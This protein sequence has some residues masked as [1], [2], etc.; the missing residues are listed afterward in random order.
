MLNGVVGDFTFAARLVLPASAAS[1]AGRRTAVLSTLF[2][3]DTIAGVFS[4]LVD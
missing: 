4:I 1:V 3:N 2:N